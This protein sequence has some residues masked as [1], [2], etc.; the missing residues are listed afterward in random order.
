MKLFN[1]GFVNKLLS[2]RAFM[3]LSRLTYCAY[4]IHWTYITMFFAHSRKPFY[5]TVFNQVHTYFG[6]LVAVFGLSFI[7]SLTVEAPFLNLEKL[8][9]SPLQ[10]KP[11]LPESFILF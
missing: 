9:F 6:F 10:S 1:L 3:P 8:L 4:L 5:Y 7:V 11:S 2:W